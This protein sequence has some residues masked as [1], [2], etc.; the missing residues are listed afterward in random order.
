MNLKETIDI[1]LANI[2]AAYPA[3]RECL[4]PQGREILDDCLQTIDFFRNLQPF[5]SVAANRIM[6][7]CE[8]ISNL[9]RVV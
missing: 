8:I 1:K 4:S 2:K 9:C 3:A 6:K 5:D 7:E